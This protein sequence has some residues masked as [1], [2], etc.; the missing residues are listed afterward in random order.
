MGILKWSKSGNKKLFLYLKMSTEC[1]TKLLSLGKEFSDKVNADV[2]AVA[3][4]VYDFI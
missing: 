3:D 4:D 1:L 2:N